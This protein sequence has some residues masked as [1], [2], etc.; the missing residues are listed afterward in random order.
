MHLWP[1]G[2]AT[3]GSAFSGRQLWFA[4]KI[5][6]AYPKHLQATHKITTEKSKLNEWLFLFSLVWHTY[7][8]QV[9]KVIVAP[10]HTRQN[11][12]THTHLVGLPWTSDQPVQRALPQNTQHSRQTVIGYAWQDSNL[13]SQQRSSHR[14]T[15]VRPLGSAEWL[16]RFTNYGDFN[17]F[18]CSVPFPVCHKWLSGTGKCEQLTNNEIESSHQTHHTVWFSH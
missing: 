8:L 9:K 1:S 6:S 15:P 14:P 17:F 4:H 3:W 18:G 5:H 10:D 11:T 7:S 12:H 2:N 13:K 16:L